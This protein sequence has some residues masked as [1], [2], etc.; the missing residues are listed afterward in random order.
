MNEQTQFALSEYDETIRAVLDSGGEFRIYPKGTSMLP[1]L[2]QG[3]DSVVLEKPKGALKCGDIAFYLRDGG[4]YVLHR[5]MRSESGKYTM[6][7]DN[8]LRLEE[9][10]L[11]RHIIGVVTRFYRSDRCVELSSLRYR[12]FVFLWRSFFLRRVYFKLRNIK[13][14]GK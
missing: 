7:G 6:C 3:V 2:R 4:G 11:D 13:N 8:Q 5:V 12:I 9:G 10:I 14:R 1:L